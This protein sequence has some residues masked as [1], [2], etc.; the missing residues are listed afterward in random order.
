MNHYEDEQ[1]ILDDHLNQEVQL[2][3]ADKAKRFSNYFIDIICAIIFT[4]VFSA[5]LYI[6]FPRAEPAFITIEEDILLSR[7]MA[8]FFIFLY[9]FICESVFHGKSIGKF[10]TKTRVVNYHGEVPESKTF[11]IRSLSRIVPFEILSFL[12]PRSDGWHDRW[13]KTMV[14]DERKSRL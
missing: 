14:I 13:S 6:A 11:L 1:Q 4:F 10:I 7:L 12:G 9:Y 8:S 5:L 2:I 3:A